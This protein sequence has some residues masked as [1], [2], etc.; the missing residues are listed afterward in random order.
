MKK[1]IAIV[2][3]IIV[4]ATVGYVG[5]KY[6]VEK[7]QK[8]PENNSQAEEIYTPAHL[9]I[10][11]KLPPSWVIEKDKTSPTRITFKDPA[12]ITDNYNK[13]LAYFNENN[14]SLGTVLDSLSILTIKHYSNFNEWLNDKN[15]YGTSFENCSSV[16]EC[17]KAPDTHIE[18]F[19]TIGGRNAFH[20]IACGEICHHH[21]VVEEKDIYEFSTADFFGNNSEVVEPVI[22]STIFLK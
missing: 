9:K 20:V 14:I 18:N 2:A 8:Q 21:Y 4:L 19:S 1:Y 5:G 22:K 15:S 11:I 10:S 3:S 17:Y 12:H 6:I 7:V 16:R 13:N